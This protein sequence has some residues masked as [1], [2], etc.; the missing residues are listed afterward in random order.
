MGKS[1]TCEAIVLQ[2]HDVGEADRFCI[3]L[4]YERGRLAARARGVRK[5]KS[6]MGGS[7]L[8]LRCIT[9][10][11]YE[12]NTGFLITAVHESSEDHP[13]DIQPFLYAEQGIELLLK[14]VEDDEAIPDIFD[15]TKEFLEQCRISPLSPV[16]PFTIR[17]LALLGLF[18]SPKEGLLQQKLHT[19]ESV[20]LETCM[21]KTWWKA[22]TISAQQKQRIHTLCLRIIAQQT[23]QELRAR[24][25][26]ATIK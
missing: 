14:L 19:E 24:L 9:I 22:T 20:F 13:K 5:L 2:T 23:S 11:L 25:V 12:S 10:D 17:L 21:S 16:L 7:I 1:I 6:R 8:P 26:A 4:T 3:L 18:P 15:A